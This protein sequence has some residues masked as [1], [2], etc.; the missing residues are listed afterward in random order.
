MKQLRVNN[1]CSGCG[2]CVMNCTYLRE[3]ED[4]NAEVIP[5][6]AIAE[7]DIKTIQKIV[8]DCPE[9]ALEIISTGSTAGTGI[10]G[11][12]AVVR[13]LDRELKAI[14][15]DEVDDSALDFD[16]D[17]FDIPIPKG[18]VQ[19][20]RYSSK[21]AAKSAAREEFQRLCYSETAYRPI[22]KK[23]FV[24]YKVKRLRPY[25]TCTDTPDSAYYAY[26]QKVRKLLA[27]ARAE[28]NMLLGRE[29]VP[30]LWQE[31]SVYPSTKDWVIEVLTRFDDMS[32]S[33]GIIQNLR[34]EGEYTRLSW[35]IDMM[36]FDDHEEYAG[37]GLFGHTRYKKVWEISGFNEQ[38]ES[39]I[40]DLRL[41]IG[42]QSCDL[43]N[44]AECDIN[45]ALK[46]FGE[47]LKK[48]IDEKLT[49]LKQYV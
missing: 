21:S 38:V 23:V 28:I 8:Q 3:N 7:Q 49:Q 25:Y 17:S 11:A 13:K 42:S 36:D 12:Q 27:D 18:R 46:E 31:F 45:A 15:V 41:A 16:A 32:T 26:N 40:E 39:Y 14:E 43:Q 35:Y 20:K 9:G 22:L 6:K 48:A 24:E 5:G 2:L 37:E 1:K 4:G 19:Y 34:E 10:A 29:A 44:T 47:K 30:Q 33:S